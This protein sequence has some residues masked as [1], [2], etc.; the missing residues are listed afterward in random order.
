M[1]GTRS[2]SPWLGLGLGLRL[3]SGLGSGLGLGLGLGLS[4]AL[5]GLTFL[6]CYTVGTPALVGL[7]LRMYL[8]PAAKAKF[9]G[10]PML[11]RAK[12]RSGRDRGEIGEK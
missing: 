6:L 8:S 2:T 12:A 7:S 1:A 10:T 11:A 5:Q 3:G 4:G 9:K